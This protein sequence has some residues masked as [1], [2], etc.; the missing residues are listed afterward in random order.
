[1]RRCGCTWDCHAILFLQE[2]I[3]T[4]LNKRDIY[5][6]H[7]SL[8]S[9]AYDSYSAL[10]YPLVFCRVVVKWVPVVVGLGGIAIESIADAQKSRFRYVSRQCNTIRHCAMI[11]WFLRSMLYHSHTALERTSLLLDPPQCTTLHQST[12][13]YSTLICTTFLF[14]VQSGC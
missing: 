6:Q 7:S 10:V 4:F 8:T 3:T 9:I 14:V 1:M 5:L 11:N 2:D 12:I 13:H